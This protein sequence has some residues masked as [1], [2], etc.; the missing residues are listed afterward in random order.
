MSLSFLPLSSFPRATGGTPCFSSRYHG[1][2]SQC[3]FHPST[4]AWQNAVAALVHCLWA[5]WQVPIFSLSLSIIVCRGEEWHTLKCI[6]CFYFPRLRP[7]ITMICQNY[8]Q[9]EE[10]PVLGFF[11]GGRKVFFPRSAKQLEHSELL[12]R[13][14]IPNKRQKEHAIRWQIT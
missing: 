4:T 13:T 6:S 11:S 8:R 2:C 1:P 14:L 9:I 10:V 5:A 3:S 12:L 7:S